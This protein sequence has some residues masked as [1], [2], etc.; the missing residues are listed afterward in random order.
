MSDRGI[1]DQWRLALVPVLLMSVT[2]A[3]VASGFSLFLRNQAPMPDMR[4][5]SPKLTAYQA[6]ASEFDT[7]FIGTS[8]TFYHIVPDDLETA[9][10]AAGCPRP[11]VFNFGVFGLTGAEQD[12]LVDRLL[13][14]GE[15]ALRTVVI[16]D[17]LSEA[18]TLDKAT[19]ERARYF[20]GPTDYAA[21]SS[22]ISSFP[23]SSLKKIFRYG[24]FGAGAAYDLSGVGRASALFFPAPKQPEPF[25]IDLER[26]GFEILGSFATTD[27]EARRKDFLDHPERLKAA[28]ARYGASSDESVV[29]RA[30]YLEERLRRIRSLGL[31]AVLFVSPD[32]EELDRTPRVGVEVSRI[33]PDLPVLNFNRPDVYPD[34]FEHDVWFDKSHYGE[35]GA[36]TLSR[37]AGAELCEKLTPSNGGA[38]HAIR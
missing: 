28:M 17:P 5:L 22:S 2:F 1:L 35:A 30:A 7:V 16:E 36:R 19:N 13:E 21:I 12:W 25:S 8:R 9:V 15:G 26:D 33:A 20:H 31:N 3:V 4:V 37:V 38:Q 18:R 10:E 27:I 6:R 14:A 23:E 24:I 11:N 29:A 32:P 34:L